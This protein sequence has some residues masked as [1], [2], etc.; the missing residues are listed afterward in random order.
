MNRRA[1]ASSDARLQNANDDLEDWQMIW[2]GEF[3]FEPKTGFRM[4][5]YMNE[6]W[7]NYDGMP[8]DVVNLDNLSKEPVRKILFWE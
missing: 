7:I 4:D 6:F 1:I 8:R 3:F 2:A 5:W